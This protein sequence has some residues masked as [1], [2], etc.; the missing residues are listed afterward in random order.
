MPFTLFGGSMEPQ[1]YDFYQ[2]LRSRIR[3]WPKSKDRSTGKWSEYFLFAPDLFHLVCKLS[4]D[5]EVPAK[6]KLKLAGAIA[7]FVSPF[8]LMPEAFGGV[9]GFTDD[10]A[11][12]VYVLNSL[13]NGSH[14]DTLKRNWAGEQDIL[15]LIEK[16]MKRVD[17]MG[18]SNR[19]GKSVWEKV[20]NMFK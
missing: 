18:S 19:L 14:S 16:V 3:E 10:I 8:D 7:Y 1:H 11:L 20:K 13:V 4:I 12:A 9:I 17:S 15:K 6:A 5:S 2:K